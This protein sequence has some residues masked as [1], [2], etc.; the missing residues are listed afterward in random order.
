[1]PL[2]MNQNTEGRNIPASVETDWLQVLPAERQDLF[3][4]QTEDWE[5]NYTMFSMTLNSA[6]AA[7][8]Q[9]ELVQARQQ[10]ACAA[11]LAQRLSHA[12]LPT[13]GALSGNYRWKRSPT[14]EPLQPHLFRGESARGVATWNAL[15]HWPVFPRHWRFG[16]K[17]RV[18]RHAIEKVTREFCEVARDLA[19]GVSVRPSTGWLSLEALHDDLNT[20]LREAFVTLKSFLCAVSVEG[21]RLFRAALG[22]SNGKGLPPERGISPASP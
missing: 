19:E 12:L 11:D 18:L 22:E 17:L 6:I 14:V 13:L 15:L 2:S 8:S 20:M 1:M 7:R 21:Y 4:A 3:S 5:R 9:G 16:L 10:V